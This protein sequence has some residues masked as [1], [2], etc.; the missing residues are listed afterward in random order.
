MTE[1]KNEQ[2]KIKEM[3]ESAKKNLE[4]S[5]Y[6]DI[7]GSNALKSN[8]YEF[9]QIGTNSGNNVYQESLSGEKAQKIRQEFYETEKKEYERLGVAGEPDY[10]S[11][12][13]ISAYVL[14]IMQESVQKTKLSELEKIVGIKGLEIPEDVKKLEEDLEGRK[15]NIDDINDK[16]KSKIEIMMAYKGLA[17]E[18][19]KKKSALNIMNGHAYDDIKE[20]YKKLGEEFKKYSETKSD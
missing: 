18:A 8:P 9:G 4:D 15:L 1:E 10:A 12:P 19:L 7:L 5:F 13:R 16:D 17:F 3:R 14:K 11:N 6:L 2:E 20:T